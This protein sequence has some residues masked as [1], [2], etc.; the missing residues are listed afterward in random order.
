MNT[1]ILVLAVKAIV[2]S[3]SSPRH[4]QPGSLES[5]ILLDPGPVKKEQ[6]QM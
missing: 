3:K 5:D 6:L 2:R 4:N 1:M